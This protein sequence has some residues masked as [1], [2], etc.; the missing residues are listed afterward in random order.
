MKN[1]TVLVGAASPRIN[2]GVVDSGAFL[3][4]ASFPQSLCTTDS[5]LPPCLP[6]L[7][8]SGGYKLQAKPSFHLQ[9]FSFCIPIEVLSSFDQI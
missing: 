9:I 2:F 8:L 1:Y 5:N 6:S 4:W 3:N 7:V